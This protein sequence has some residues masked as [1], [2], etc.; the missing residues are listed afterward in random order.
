MASECGRLSE[1]QSGLKRTHIVSQQ[2]AL[3]CMLIKPVLSDLCMTQLVS[4]K[5][6]IF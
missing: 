1:V 3:Q 5:R 2:I 4:H 6:I